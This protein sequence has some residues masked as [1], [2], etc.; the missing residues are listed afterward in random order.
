MAYKTEE[1]LA[2]SLQ[3]IT[4]HK[5]IFIEDVVAYLPCVKGTFYE[6]KLHESDAI[7]ELLEKNKTEI[8]VSM[9]SK[10]YKS[11][12]A[13]LQMALM[14]LISTDNERKLLSMNYIDHTTKG[15]KINNTTVLTNLSDETLKE[16]AEKLIT[17]SEQT[18]E[19][20]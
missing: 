5:L 18:S 14:K 13:T 15:D 20:N 12:N 7:K 19:N 2:L 6:H 4:K 10:W 3:A 16:L 9:R 1:L 8:K 11:G 17:D